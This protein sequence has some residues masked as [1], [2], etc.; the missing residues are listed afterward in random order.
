MTRPLIGLTLDWCERGTFSP[1]PHYALRANYFNAIWQAGGLPVALPLITTAQDDYLDR[2]HGVLVPGG[3]YPSPGWWYGDSHGSDDHPRAEAD[4]ALIRKVL[5][6]HMPLLG[7]CAG[8]QTLTVA[9][10]GILHWRVREK[11]PGA[12]DHRGVPLE[13]VSHTVN[14]REGSL[15]REIMG[16]ATVNVN[17]HHNEGVARVGE[18]VV[19]S[20]TAEDGVVEAV[21]ISGQPFAL[22]V[23]WHPEMQ[24]TP[25]DAAVFEAFVRAA[26]TYAEQQPAG[27]PDAA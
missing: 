15:L 10:G 27:V 21:E 5:E 4:V 17:S 1:R 23:Q 7:I 26:K 14:V 24:V 22:G 11:V 12:L 13:N 25:H 19:V 20:G 9:T 16:E 8:L 2:V 3:D 6:R 18:G